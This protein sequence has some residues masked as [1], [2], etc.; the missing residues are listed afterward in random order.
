MSR[1]RL[2]NGDDHPE[3]AGKRLSDARVLLPAG[4]ADGAAYLA[5]YVVECSLKSVLLHE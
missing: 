2:P 4:R 5:G 1:L 3:A